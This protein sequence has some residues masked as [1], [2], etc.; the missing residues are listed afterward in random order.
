MTY[1][2]VNGNV[3]NF[4]ISGQGEPLLLISDRGV[5]HT[6]WAHQ[7]SALSAAMMTICFDNRGTGKSDSPSTPYS[8]ELM[9]EDGFGLMD[10]IG[11]DWAHVMGL[12]MGGRIALQMALSRPSRVKRLVLSSSSPRP[13]PFENHLMRAMLSSIGRGVS[14][15][16]L[17]RFEVPWLLSERF[18][19]DPRVAEAVSRVRMLRTRGTPPLAHAR[20]IEAELESDLTSQLGDVRPPTLVVAGR[21]DLLVPYDY[22]ARMAESIPGA[23]LLPL[24]A[25]HMVN[26]EQPLEFNRGAL[27]FI[28]GD[29]TG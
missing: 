16:D 5:D 18:F 4:E 8:I 11:L 12:G 3:L 10:A 6:V 28:L 9:A 15:E 27:S 29:S 19:M 20:Q 21:N 24:D 22:Q 23:A 14:N 13:T 7:I 1:V 17:A 26:T 2:R 25:A